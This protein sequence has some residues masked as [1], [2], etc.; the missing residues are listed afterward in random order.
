MKRKDIIKTLKE[1]MNEY[2]ELGDY[3]CCG[4]SWNEAV[5]F[6]MQLL[7]GE[8]EKEPSMVLPPYNDG[9]NKSLPTL[10][11]WSTIPDWVQW[12]VT[13]KSLG[14]N[15]DTRYFVEGY[16]T[17]P[18]NAGHFYHTGV[19]NGKFRILTEVKPVTNAKRI[20][21]TIEKRPITNRAAKDVRIC[22]NEN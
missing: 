8:Y 18:V 16:E 1:S 14:A 19:G 3:D 12:C 10:Y 11:D 9:M 22:G 4:E 15:G 5:Y 21:D 13:V 20:Q 6:A 7:T 2:D 17:E